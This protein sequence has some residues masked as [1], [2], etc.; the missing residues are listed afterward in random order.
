M[1]YK[2]L[3]LV[4]LILISCRKS[5]NI[6]P[7]SNEI[8]LGTFYSKNY[9]PYDD[10]Q[11]LSFENKNGA[12]K[13]VSVNHPT[14]LSFLQVPPKEIYK[15]NECSKSSGVDNYEWI[16]E[17]NNSLLTT[18]VDNKTFDILIEENAEML[19]AENDSNTYVI[20][21]RYGISLSSQFSE[22]FMQIKYNDIINEE[23][24]EELFKY[25]DLLMIDNF[26]LENVYYNK[27]QLDHDVKVIFFRLN[28]GIVGLI[29]KHDNY[30]NLK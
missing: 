2:L 11:V 8:N 24:S 18:V 25:D 7:C 5:E 16:I 30:W 29:D 23:K 19:E 12:E 3:F 17:Q 26:K 1:K 6:E 20:N 27:V 28:E 22:P 14:Q 10:F 13:T 21:F 9:I 4:A 15:E